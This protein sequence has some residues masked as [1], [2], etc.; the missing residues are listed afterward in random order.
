MRGEGVRQAKRKGQK[1]LASCLQQA[2]TS[3]ERQR[4]RGP[5]QTQRSN[6]WVTAAPAAP[7]VPEHPHKGAE[8]LLTSFEAGPAEWGSRGMIQKVH[9]AEGQEPRYWLM[10]D[11]AKGAV[12][13]IHV[14]ASWCTLVA[15]L[16]ARPK[17]PAPHT[18]DGR[19]KATKEFLQKTRAKMLGNDHPS[20]VE[21]GRP[22]IPH[23]TTATPTPADPPVDFPSQALQERK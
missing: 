8:V 16:P 9:Q 6:S 5:G 1:L 20:S 19:A 2:R 18:L 13:C 3:R 12:R 15:D 23:P 10:L 14:P 4:P 17:A 22:S 7:E 11:S 21:V